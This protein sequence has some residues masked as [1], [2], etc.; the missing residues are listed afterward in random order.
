M[1]CRG[2]LFAI[3]DDDVRSLLALTDHAAVVDYV[4]ETIEERW[5][6][7]YLAETD[8]AWDAMHR[9]LT[10]GTFKL[11]G[12]Q[13]PLS[14]CILG[15]RLLTTEDGYIVTF[16]A[17]DEAPTVAAAL[18]TVDRDYL[19]HAYDRI[20]ADDYGREFISDEDFEY[21]WEYFQAT[22]ALWQRAA[23]SGRAV[24][25]AVDQ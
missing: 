14:R 22:R 13:T 25:F 6:E 17:A 23:E 9:C 16:T 11:G 5:E 20:D 4:T 12:G 24:I 8:K 7:E 1:A 10:D 21:T 19:R 18:Q 2:V 15:G 3:A